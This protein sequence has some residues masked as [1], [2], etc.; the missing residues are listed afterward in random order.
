MFQLIKYSEL[1]KSEFWSFFGI[2]EQE[3]VEMEPG[4][5][6]KIIK[7]GG[8]QEFVDIEFHVNKND[9]VVKAVLKL[10]RS[11]VG[12]DKHLNPFAQDISKSFIDVLTNSADKANMQNLIDIMFKVHGSQDH[13]ISLYSEIKID[14]LKKEIKDVIDTMLGL[15]ESSYIQLSGGTFKFNNIKENENAK[16]IITF[17]MSIASFFFSQ[18]FKF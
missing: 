6:K 4:K 14:K 5:L 10:D 2:T 1:K 17:E 12:D 3:S 11:W 13:V 16:F 7:P 18:S 9:E 15:K 8:F